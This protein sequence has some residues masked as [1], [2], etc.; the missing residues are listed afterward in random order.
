MSKSS[1]S[2]R[3][4]AG[5]IKGLSQYLD[6]LGLDLRTLAARQEP[7]IGPPESWENGYVS[8]DR[9]VALLERA[10]DLQGDPLFGLRWSVR[11]SAGGFRLVE[12]AMRFAPT[13]LVGLETMARFSAL[14]LDVRNNSVTIGGDKVAFSWEFA[15]TTQQ[16]NQLL[17]RYAAIVVGR[18]RDGFGGAQILPVAVELNRPAPVSTNLHRQV[19]GPSIT[20]AAHT[21]RIVF[22]LDQM[23]RDNPEADPEVFAAMVELC[24]RRL[25]ERGAAADFAGHVREVVRSK[26]ASPDLNLGVVARELGM[27]PRVVQRRL[28][29]T[30]HKFQEI[31]DD[32]R[33][34]MAA[35]LL[36]STLLPVS[37]ISFRLGFSAVGNFTRASRRWFGMTPREMRKGAA[38]RRLPE[39]DLQQATQ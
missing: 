20:F 28:A 24:E 33:R 18:F 4:H 21:N 14:G 9:Y 30:G 27:S 37:E 36:R 35:D 16:P 1:G 31:H 3:I 25:S 2:N 38:G 23:V 6:Q 12:L 39:I 29:E 22:R 10:A 8:L 34:V 5:V 13:P 11:Q 32:L 26:I 19:F 17:D 15:P 7:E